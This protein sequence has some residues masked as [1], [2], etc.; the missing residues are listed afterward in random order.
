MNKEKNKLGKIDFVMFIVIMALVTIGVVMVYSASSYISFFSK[1]YKYD[2][3]FFLKKQLL[4]ACIGTLGMII[5]MRL[6][7]H[8]LKK[9]TKIGTVVTFVLL[10]LVLGSTPI[11]G[12]RRW[13]NLGFST[14]QPSEIAK[15][16]VVFI[17]AKS[18]EERNILSNNFFRWTTW[19]LMVG[20][21]FAGLILLEPNMS[22]ACVIMFVVFIVLF[23]TG[24]KKS[25]LGLYLICGIAA[26]VL[27]IV[28]SEYRLDRATSF[29]NPWAKQQKEGYQLVQ[30]LLALGAGGIFGTGFGMSRQKCFFI[31]EPHNDFIL[32]IIGEE[33]GLIGCLLIVFL[34]IVFI[35]RGIM[36]ASKAKD[37]YGHV[38]AVGITS[39]VGVQAIINI[40]VISG[41]MP[42]TGVPL[43]FISYGG[44]SLV[45][46]ML[47]MGVLLNITR[48]NK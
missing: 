2:S 21:L 45:F 1:D 43:P 30:S 48:Q 7:Y 34:Y 23:S 44:S 12:A 20:G 9:I 13:I 31:P 3:M 39:V 32:P 25:H 40:A 19:Y 14:I 42:V 46:N 6:D 35:W 36:T 18:M 38:L 8:A 29:L 27:L 11:K 24:T 37:I 17:L 33:L 47:A 16:M 15:Y 5:T 4:W 10:I 28:T 22:I 41:A 26:G